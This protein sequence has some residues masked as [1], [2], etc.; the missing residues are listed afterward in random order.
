MTQKEARMSAAA[1]IETLVEG[2]EEGHGEMIY[3]MLENEGDTSAEAIEQVTE[4]MAFLVNYMNKKAY[5]K[6]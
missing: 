5:G 1:V 6:K 2:G 3:C 4:Q